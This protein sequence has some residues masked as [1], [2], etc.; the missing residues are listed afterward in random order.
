MLLSSSWVLN[1][2]QMPLGKSKR[3]TYSFGSKRKMLPQC[4][5]LKI[6][7]DIKSAPRFLTN[8]HRIT[9]W[10]RLERPSGS[11]WPNLHSRDSQRRVPRPKTR[12]LLKVSKEGT[13][14]PLV[15][16]C[17]CSVTAAW[18]SEGTFCVPV[19]AHCLLSWHW[20]PPRRAWLHLCTPISSELKLPIQ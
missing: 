15:S 19:C 11:I 6:L 20:A 8:S 14:Q 9:E 5:Y 17:Q 7:L 10:L 1:S 18:C 16:L 12:W 13:P 4:E 3:L 2:F